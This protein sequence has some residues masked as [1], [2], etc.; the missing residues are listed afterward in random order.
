MEI[1][2]WACSVLRLRDSKTTGDGEFD[3]DEME[4]L[5]LL[6]ALSAVIVRAFRR[7]LVSG[8]DEEGR[9]QC[10]KSH[11]GKGISGSDRVVSRRGECT[12]CDVA[13]VVNTQASSG[14]GLE[15]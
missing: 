3:S 13:R 6:S 14:G 7:G 1:A 4:W 11:K 2:E 10:E 5:V 12:V 15:N 8:S 9:T